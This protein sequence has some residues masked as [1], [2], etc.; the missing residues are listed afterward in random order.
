MSHFVYVLHNPKTGRLY[1]GR[2]RNLKRR[3]EQHKK[4]KL[5]HR[6]RYFTCIFA[7]IFTNEADASRRESY[8]KSSK[9]KYTLKAMLKNT[10]SL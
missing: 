9:G 7:E 2:T 5:S 4:S 10:L 6:N 8:L 3:L 1:V